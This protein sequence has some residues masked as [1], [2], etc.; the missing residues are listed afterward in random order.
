MAEAK[1]RV[2]SSPAP[3]PGTEPYWEGARQGKLLLRGCKS[4]GRIH[5]YPRALCPHCFSGELDWR[6]ASG[7]G[8]IYTFTVMRRAPVPYCIGYVTLEEGISMM[9]NIVD[10]DLDTVRI[11]QKVKVVFKPSENGQPVPMFTPV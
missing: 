2:P 5:H 4:C 6:E 10:C 9:T 11:G 8:T 7:A 1:V 3:T